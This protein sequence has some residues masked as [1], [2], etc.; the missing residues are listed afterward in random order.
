MPSLCAMVYPRH[1]TRLGIVY[2]R[3]R[4]MVGVAI[5]VPSCHAIRG[6]NCTHSD[7]RFTAPPNRNI[8][9]SL[10]LMDV[11]HLIKFIAV[12]E[13]K[14]FELRCLLFKDL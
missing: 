13:L 2:S 4:P 1:D 6:D 7:H 9:S 5:V 14:L 10:D 3:V 11:S 8:C 12:A